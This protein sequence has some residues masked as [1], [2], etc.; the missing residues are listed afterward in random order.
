MCALSR[1][2]FIAAG[3]IAALALS[4]APGRADPDDDEGVYRHRHDH[5]R[6][7]LA[8][9]RGEARPLSE[10]LAQ[11]RPELG[12]EVTGVEFRRKAGKWLYEFRVIGAGGQMTEVYVDAATAEI[13]K[14]EA[15]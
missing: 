11:V 15:H 9:E 7:R 5:D 8:V 4:S 13:V 10:I 12:G 2:A 3:V 1:R 14:R 6:A